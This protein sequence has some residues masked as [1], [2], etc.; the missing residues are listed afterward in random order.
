VVLQSIDEGD[1]DSM[2]KNC[3]L[4]LHRYPS[5]S[6]TCKVLLKHIVTLRKEWDP[7]LVE[8]FNGDL[9]LGMSL[10]NL[11]PVCAFCS[12]FFDPEYDDGVTPPSKS[13]PVVPSTNPVSEFCIIEYYHYAC[14][15]L[16]YCFVVRC[17]QLSKSGNSS[18]RPKNKTLTE[19]YDQR[20]SGLKGAGELLRDPSTVETRARAKRAVELAAIMKRERELGQHQQR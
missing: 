1:I 13:K 14:V 2:K 4:C 20:H 19:Y 12:Q 9:S 8:K 11:V 17:R 18:G 5:K 3:F 10:F 7:A 15:Y 6:L 16:M